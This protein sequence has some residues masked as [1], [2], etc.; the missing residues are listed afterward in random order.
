MM[1]HT[2]NVVKKLCLNAKEYAGLNLDKM[3]ITVDKKCDE[4]EKPLVKPEIV[5]GLLESGWT[6]EDYH[7]LR[8]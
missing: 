6:M 1:Q 2:I 8:K 7:D 4:Y 5:P 3:N